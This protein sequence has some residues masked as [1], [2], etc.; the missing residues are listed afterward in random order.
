MNLHR[1]TC[2]RNRARLAINKDKCSMDLLLA[3]QLT[4]HFRSNTV[5]L[6]VSSSNSRQTSHPSSKHRHSPKRLQALRLL[7]CLPN[8]PVTSSSD[9]RNNFI[10][11]VQVSRPLSRTGRLLPS[12]L[13]HHHHSINSNRRATIRHLRTVHQSV[14]QTYLLRQGFPSVHL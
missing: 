12:M 8:S 4:L 13:P 11:K 3:V 7:A 1:L 2:N 5:S 6:Q 10:N 9:R 14:L